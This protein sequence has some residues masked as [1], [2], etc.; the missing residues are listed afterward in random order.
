MKIKLNRNN[1]IFILIVA[2]FFWGSTFAFTKELTN[3]ITPLWIV[4]IR[5][6]LTAFILLGMF[7]KQ[8]IKIF[9]QPLRKELPYLL[10]LGLV[11]FIAIL[12]QT[13]SLK[14]IPASNNGFITSFALLLVP[15]IEFIFRKKPVYNNIKLAV[16]LSLIGIYIMSYGLSIPEEFRLGDILALLSAIAYAFYIILV[17]ILSKKVNAGALMFFVF[18]VTG[19]VSLPISIAIDG[20][21]FVSSLKTLATLDFSVY[22]NMGFLIIMGTIIPYI[23][24]GVGQKRVDAQRASLIYILEPVFAMFIAVLFFSEAVFIVKIIGG[25]LIFIAQ[26][27]GIKQPKLAV[28]NKTN[29]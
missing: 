22:F 18:I 26:I 21:I 14:E 3:D 5:F 25:G 10:L 9:T 19:V 23:L 7:F 15:F 6:G 27:I 2:T 24:M 17:D 29:I 28:D 16:V 13:I 4:T 11:N 20:N 1:S 12:L 8:I